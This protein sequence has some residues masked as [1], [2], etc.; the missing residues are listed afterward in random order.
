MSLANQVHPITVRKVYRVTERETAVCV[1]Y[2]LE[3]RASGPLAVRFGVEFNLTL[4][5][6]DDPQRYY[7]VPGVGRVRLRERGCCAGADRF[8]MVDDWNRF[9][10]TLRLDRS[11]DIW[12][13]PIETVSQSE[14]GAER[15]YQGSALLASW[16]LTLNPGVTE[17]I[18]VRLEIA[19]L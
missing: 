3:S 2:A 13:M 5:A 4:L 18:E 8:A 6:G 17:R 1:A 10:V 15:I 12:Y 11:G 9:R 16:P 14:E 19:E 7:E